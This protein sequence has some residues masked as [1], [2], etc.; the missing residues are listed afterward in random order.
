MSESEDELDLSEESEDG[1]FSASEDEYV[2]PNNQE[3]SDDSDDDGEM[4]ER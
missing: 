2:P 3:S 1:D 4:S